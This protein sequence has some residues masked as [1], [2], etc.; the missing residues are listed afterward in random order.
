MSTR[1][2]L[3][4][5]SDDAPTIARA[6]EHLA[7]TASGLALDGVDCILFAGPEGDDEGEES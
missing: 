7:R 4:V 2:S 5:S 6:V 1:I 3:S